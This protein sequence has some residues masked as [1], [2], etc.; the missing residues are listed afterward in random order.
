[1]F[2]RRNPL[3]YWQSFKAFLYPKT[4]W[5]RAFSYMYYRIRRLPDTPHKIALGFA[6]GAFVCFTP[7]FGLHF[8]AAAL[9]AW[10][11]RGNVLASLIGTFIGNPLTFPIIATVSYRL[12]LWIM[13]YSREETA[14]TKIRDGFSDAGSAL[15]AN[16]KSLF[17][18]GPST[19]DGIVDFFNTVMVPYLVGGVGPGLVTAIIVY[20]ASKP[21]IRVYQNRRKG[22]ILAKFKELREKRGQKKAQSE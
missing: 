15:W 14:W 2:R 9:I 11:L 20:F 6:V 3:S 17:G 16:T 10:I 22:R 8:F 19:W 18:Y 4:G 7:F 13:D 21:A 12:G 5:K 1:V